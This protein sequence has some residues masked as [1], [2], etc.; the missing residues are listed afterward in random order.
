MSAADSPSGGD[1]PAQAH[2]DTYDHGCSMAMNR[3]DFG[4]G[5]AAIAAGAAASSGTVSADPAGSDCDTETYTPAGCIPVAGWPTRRAI[6]GLDYLFGNKEDEEHEEY[7]ENEVLRI[8]GDLYRYGVERHASTQTSLTW[9]TDNANLLEGRAYIEGLKAAYREIQEND[10][11]RQGAIDAATV[12]VDEVYS[13][14]QEEL[15]QEAHLELRSVADRAARLQLALEESGEWTDTG[16]FEQYFRWHLQGDHSDESS[17]DIHGFVP[18]EPDVEYTLFDGNTVQTYTAAVEVDTGQ[19]GTGYYHNQS[20]IGALSVSNFDV[21]PTG[22][23]SEILETWDSD[24]TSSDGRIATD[25]IWEIN[26]FDAAEYRNVYDSDFDSV[27][28]VATAW[29]M[30]TYNNAAQALIDAHSAARTSVETMVDNVYAD[31]VDDEISYQ[32]IQTFDSL[33]DQAPQDD[34]YALVNAHLSMLGRSPATSHVTIDV[35]SL[36]D[37]AASDATT[38]DKVDRLA[39]LGEVSGTL[40]IDPAPDNSLSVGQTYTPDGLT[41]DVSETTTAPTVTFSFPVETD[42]GDTSATFAEFE[43]YRQF[44]VVNAQSVNNDGDL[45]TVDEIAF[46]DSLT[47]ETP[48]N[49]EDVHNRLDEFEKFQQD[50]LKRQYDLVEEMSNQDGFAFPAIG[51]VGSSL[52]SGLVVTGIVIVGIVKVVGR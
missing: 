2:G 45:E 35:G 7:L 41:D 9:L 23:D 33:A 49:Y 50:L 16:T 29:S 15:I 34:P 5:L 12:R 31:I 30:E 32:D 42:T 10:A 22:S 24:E 47:T 11:T 28:G 26:E 44:T 3:R 43:Q 19:S 37:S 52:I 40:Y 46:E 20:N 38:N 1:R 27:D 4:K 6:D 14:P 36:S 13:T 39:D 21:S 25:F 18:D 48:T 51:E 8:H 17:G